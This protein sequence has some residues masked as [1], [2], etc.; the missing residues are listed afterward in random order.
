MKTLFYL[1]SALV[2]MGLAFWAYQENYRTQ[3][4]LRDLSELKREIG[5]LRTSQAMLEAEWAYLNRPER[6]A[7][8]AQINFDRL[9]LLPLRPDQ[10][11]PVE[12]VSFPP[13]PFLALSQPIEIMGKLKPGEEFP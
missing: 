7:E 1:S 4:K 9:G 13:P 11:D 3:A 5:D 2:V 8:L 12:N 10:L 6:L